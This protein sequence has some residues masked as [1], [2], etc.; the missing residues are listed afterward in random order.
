[1][2]KKPPILGYEVSVSG[3]DDGTIEAV[4]IHVREGKVATTREIEGDT[5]LADYDADGNVLGIEILAPVRL[6][7]VED[8][9]EQRQRRSFGRFVRSTV[10]SELVAP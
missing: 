3:R 2:D 1:M 4:Y 6:A 9:V 10:P 8:L 5:L 7:N